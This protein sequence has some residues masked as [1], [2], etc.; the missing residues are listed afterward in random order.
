V[1]FV[2]LLK[3]LFAYYEIAAFSWKVAGGYPR[4][5]SKI[6]DL[7]PLARAESGG[8]D[9]RFLRDFGLEG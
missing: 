5:S 6:G 2:Y 4:Q 9:R 3:Y 7:A 8:A 1:L